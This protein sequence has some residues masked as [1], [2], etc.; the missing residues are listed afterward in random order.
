[1]KSASE[2]IL[3]MKME[4]WFLSLLWFS[5]MDFV[6]VVWHIAKSSCCAQNWLIWHWN[7]TSFFFFFAFDSLVCPWYLF[8]AVWNFYSKPLTIK[9]T[10][11]A[12]LFKDFL[13]TNKISRH[14]LTNH[15]VIVIEIIKEKKSDSLIYHNVE[16]IWFMLNSHAHMFNINSKY[17][18]MTCYKSFLT[19][20]IDLF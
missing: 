16:M 10:S 4:S 1:M 9:S 19:Y 6:P 11:S 20:L 2:F 7:L 13:I 3:M 8:E 17:M 15:F 5:Q 18:I 14:R 12:Y